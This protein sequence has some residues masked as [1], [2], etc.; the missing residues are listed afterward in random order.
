MPAGGLAISGRISEWRYG[1]DLDPSRHG[2]TAM[3]LM[4]GALTVGR[5]ELGEVH[6]RGD[7]Y[8]HA[9]HWRF[10]SER[11]EGDLVVP[12][13]PTNER[14]V[15]ADLQRLDFPLSSAGPED[16]AT[17]VDARTV[18][19]MVLHVGDLTFGIVNLGEVNGFIRR[20]ENG[21]AMEGFTAT[22]RDMRITADASWH[23]VDGHHRSVLRGSLD[24]T[25]VRRTL[26]ALGYRGSI[27]AAA[28]HLQVDLNWLGSPLQDP[29]PILNG[30][31]SIRLERGQLSDVQAG[32]GRVF[33]LLSVNAL[34]RRLALDFRDFFGRGLAFDT[35]QGEFRVAQG[36]AHTDRMVLQGPAA[37]I[38]TSGRTGLAARDYDQ[39][40]EVIGTFRSSLALAGTLAGGPGVG[41]ALL[42]ASEILKRP[43]EDLARVQYRLT[44]SWDAPDFERI[45]EPQRDPR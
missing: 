29:L 17:E 44:G 4:I 18:S 21:I 45:E 2:V 35:L 22:R 33:G 32:A 9:W 27:E 8:D 26:A 23:T 40:V 6:V 43:L 5:R 1:G 36:D 38:T 42:I 25:D 7:R 16:E 37:R 15:Q 14:P 31:A 24:S 12:D 3:D 19:P 30:T 11:L 34:P 13:E 41:A 20:V 28:G 10:A 39:E